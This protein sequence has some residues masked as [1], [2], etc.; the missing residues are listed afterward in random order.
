MSTPDILLRSVKGLPLTHPEM[1]GNLSSF[2]T[3]TK[4]GWRDNIIQFG[5]EVGDNNA[6]TLAVFLGAIKLYAFPTNKMTQAVAIWHIDHDYAMGTDLYPHI[7]WSVA[8]PNVGT[9][10]WGF[11]YTVAKGH[12][13]QA[14]SPTTTTYVEQASLGIQYM[15]YVAEF[16]DAQA[17]SGS[18]VEPDSL[19]IARVFRDPTH[20][21]D[22]LDASVF[23]LC[24]DMHYQADRATT[25]NKSPDFYA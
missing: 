9:V 12:Q 24:L 23:G 17:I 1:D 6:P 3:R 25:P 11:E 21:N 14:F 2:N 15:H 20:P 8:T 10:R 18:L 5:V 4:Q 13:Q 22:T 16:S 7:H 19:I